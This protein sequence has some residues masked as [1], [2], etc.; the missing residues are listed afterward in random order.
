[1]APEGSFPD[2]TRP[3]PGR[4]RSGTTNNSAANPLL[5]FA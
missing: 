4:E 2:I 1:L 5:G 3:M